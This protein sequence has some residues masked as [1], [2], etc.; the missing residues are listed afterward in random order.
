M[1]SYSQNK[2]QRLGIGPSKA[3]VTLRGPRWVMTSATRKQR[4]GI[5]PSK[6][7]VMPLGK[8]SGFLFPQ[9]TKQRLGIEPRISEIGRAHV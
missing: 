3:K 4:L 6:A 7:K 5:G 8:P 9:K 1:N 2:K